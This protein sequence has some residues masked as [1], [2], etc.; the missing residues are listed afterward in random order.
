[1]AE[2]IRESMLSKEFIQIP[3]LNP[4][5][6]VGGEGAWDERYIERLKNY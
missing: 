5:V 1:M 4:I 3:C 6:T 2:D